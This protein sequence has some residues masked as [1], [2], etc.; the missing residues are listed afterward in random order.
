MGLPIHVMLGLT[1]MVSDL[2][3]AGPTEEGPLSDTG[4]AGAGGCGADRA[5]YIACASLHRR[6]TRRTSRSTRCRHWLSGHSAATPASWIEVANERAHDPRHPGE[7][8]TEDRPPGGTAIGGALDRSRFGH[9]KY[10][11]TPAPTLCYQ[12]QSPAR[13]VFNLHADGPFLDAKNMTI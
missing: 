7:A 9:F 4:T 11:R 6:A 10:I 3:G 2:L 8:Q 5:D 13:A 1:A 12:R